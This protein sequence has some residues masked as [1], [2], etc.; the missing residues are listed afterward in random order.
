M[1]PLYDY[2]GGE[3]VLK[4]KVEI[5]HVDLLDESTMQQALA[6]ASFVIHT[7]TPVGI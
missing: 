4:S 2:F 3:E 6:G 7:A 1:L 5:V